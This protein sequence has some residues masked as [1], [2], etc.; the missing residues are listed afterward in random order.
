M[1]IEYGTYVPMSYDAFDMS[2]FQKNDP[3]LAQQVADLIT[4]EKISFPGIQNVSLS[5]TM[6]KNFVSGRANSLFT[7]LDE[8][9][10]APAVQVNDVKK[11]FHFR[12]LD[13]FIYGVT[14]AQAL[15]NHGLRILKMWDNVKN[16]HRVNRVYYGNE[17][18]Y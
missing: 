15:Y 5:W 1:A 2:S 4:R 14:N 13:H 10:V 7:I 3:A 8:W 11:N 9:S 17:A 18:G 12:E 16:E 6:A